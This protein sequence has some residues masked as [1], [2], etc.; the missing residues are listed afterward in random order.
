MTAAEHC[1]NYKYEER[2]GLNYEGVYVC[3]RTLVKYSSDSHK[4]SHLNTWIGSWF[5][6]HIALCSQPSDYMYVHTQSN[7][8]VLPA[9]T[10]FWVPL[11]VATG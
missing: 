5:Q 3:I 7:T 4:V 11:T 8:A 9:N 10:A 1:L 2:K 6:L